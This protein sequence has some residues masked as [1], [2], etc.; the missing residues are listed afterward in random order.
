M[1]ALSLPIHHYTGL[2]AL[3]VLPSGRIIWPVLGGNGEGD[4]G[5][6]DGGAASAGGSGDGGGQAAGQGEGGGD[7][8]GKPENQTFS[9]AD[10]DRIV[11]ERLGRERSSKADYDDLKAKAA[12]LD[13]L[14]DAQASESEKAINKATKE[15]EARVRGQLEPQ[16]ARL[17]VAIAKGLPPELGA[18]VLSAAK[19]L[20]GGTREELEA[21]AKEF[22]EAAPINIGQQQGGGNGSGFDQ[23]SRGGGGTAKPTVASGR[24]AYRQLLGKNKT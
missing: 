5:T 8:G 15:T 23:G 9:Q 4:G 6:G 7:N 11:R 1:T 24:E 13:K 3:G 12:E 2:R 18:K 14:R 10:V 21:D 19:R 17:E 16:M 20:V 22:F